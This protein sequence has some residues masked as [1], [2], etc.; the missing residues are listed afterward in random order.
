[1]EKPFSELFNEILEEQKKLENTNNKGDILVDYL[2][3]HLETPGKFMEYLKAMH[4]YLPPIERETNFIFYICSLID[5][6]AANIPFLNELVLYL[7]DNKTTL[8]PFDILEIMIIQDRLDIAEML[9]NDFGI[10]IDITKEKVTE[11]LD[12]CVDKGGNGGDKLLSFLI[13]KGIVDKKTL[14]DI[15][16]NLLE[17]G[18]V[19]VIDKTK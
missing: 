15:E 11:W 3:A 19:N 17:L 2:G 4:E 12:T 7:K 10:G 1:M 9:Y 14:T 13:S 5:V 8:T 18:N 16:Q 6:F